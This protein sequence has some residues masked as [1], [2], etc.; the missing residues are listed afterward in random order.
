M[1]FGIIAK[2]DLKAGDKIFTFNQKNIIKSEKIDF[3][4]FFQNTL[5]L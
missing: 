2:E 5:S 4:L 3:G 1:R